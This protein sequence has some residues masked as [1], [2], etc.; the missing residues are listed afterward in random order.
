MVDLLVF[1]L[2]VAITKQG[3][4]ETGFLVIFLLK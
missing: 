4:C 1:F 3:E 2:L